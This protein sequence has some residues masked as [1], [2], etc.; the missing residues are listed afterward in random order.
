VRLWWCPSGPLA[1][2][3]LHAAGYHETRF[4]PVPRMVADRAVSS[5][6]PTIRSLSYARRPA[7]PPAAS[8]ARALVV[9][10]PHTP[11]AADLPAATS[12]AGILAGALGTA[13]R[14]LT[15][16]DATRDKVT[17]AMGTYPWAH[18]A[19]HG[20][21]RLADPSASRL[22]LADHR[23]RPLTVLDV[24]RLRLSD[25]EFAYLS[26]CSTART[27]AQLPDEAIHLAA[28]FHLA[29]YRHVIGTLWPAGDRAA[30][31]FAADVYP[32]LLADGDASQAASTLHDTV[33][34]LRLIHAP[35]PSVWAGHI[36]LGG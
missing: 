10:M 35:R 18:F 26:A 17:A 16:P 21:S 8:E 2:L 4:D 33:L 28:A 11:G 31:A 23:S 13:A 12:E 22:L 34:T 32:V 19:C 25:A 30:L 24:I 9:A 20:D 5:Y 3:P 1:F 6:L 29:G 36:H 7:A 15:G 27:G 14:V